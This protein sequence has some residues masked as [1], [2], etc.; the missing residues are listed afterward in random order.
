MEGIDYINQAPPDPFKKPL[1]A[2]LMGRYTPLHWASYKGYHQIV[3]ML[4]QAGMSPHD[5][6]MHGNNA[7]HHAAAGGN[8]PVMECFL[9]MGFDIG[10]KNARGHSPLDLATTDEMINLIKRATETKQ[11]A[12]TGQKF[13]F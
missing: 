1:N 7:V 10:V 9:S 13:D 6:D 4:L 11:C 12:A 3:W 5:I 2:A 8:I